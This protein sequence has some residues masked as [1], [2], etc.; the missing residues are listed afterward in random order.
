DI[1]VP[2]AAV[3]MGACIIEK[4]FT[5]DKNLPGP[6]HRASLEPDELKEMIRQ[7]RLVEKA[8]GTGEKKPAES[9]MEVQKVARKSIVARVNIQKGSIITRG[10]LAIKR[11]GTGLVPK[12]YYK[13]VGKKAKKNIKENKLMDWDMVE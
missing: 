12:Y 2:V 8:L 6:D 7:I 9:E 11:P 3:V 4:H 1:T 5:L 10:M 13:I